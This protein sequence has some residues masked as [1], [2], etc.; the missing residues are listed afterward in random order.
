MFKYKRV[1]TDSGGKAIFNTG[2]EEEGEKHVV[3]L[4]SVELAKPILATLLYFLLQ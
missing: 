2:R 4:W 3:V 1:C